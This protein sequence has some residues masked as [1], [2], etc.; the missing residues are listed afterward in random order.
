MRL[1]IDLDE[2]VVEI[3]NP[4]LAYYKEK[5]GKSILKEEIYT[6]H[7]QEIW[8][9]SKEEENDII[10]GFYASN[11]FDNLKPYR[12]VLESLS[13]LKANNELY[14]ITSRWGLGKDKT[15]KFLEDNL[16]GLISK[17]IFTSEHSKE[18]LKKEEICIKY[19][20]PLHIE[21]DPNIAL[22][23]AELDVKVL[24]FNR[25]WNK[26]ILH[27]NITRISSW[28]EVFKTLSNKF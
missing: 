26:S 27:K 13:K 28:P 5:T 19:S 15:H 14:I 9:C 11:Y 6:P 8:H 3:M 22:K 21:D 7:L 10:N 16:N 1:G 17:I 24:L 23:C 18:G 12:G 4:L 2:T 25:P 20:I